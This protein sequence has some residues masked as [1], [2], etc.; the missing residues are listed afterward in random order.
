MKP[1]KVVQVLANSE[2]LYYAIDENGN[3]L[4]SKEITYTGILVNTTRSTVVEF[5]KSLSTSE[6]SKLKQ[7][8]EENKIIASRMP[9]LQSIHFSGDF[10]EKIRKTINTVSGA[11]PHG[12]RSGTMSQ[13]T[14]EMLEKIT[15]VVDDDPSF[16]HYTFII[17]N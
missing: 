9:E 4:V 16:I 12:T 15:A 1:G 3:S 8:I 7:F 13:A 11:G 17:K 10:I 6:K 2:K 14:M 5:K